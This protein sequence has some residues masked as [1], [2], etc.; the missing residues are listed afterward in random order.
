VYN[1]GLLSLVDGAERLG[2]T[3][4]AGLQELDAIGC[5]ATAESI[6]ALGFKENCTKLKKLDLSENKC[7]PSSADGAKQLGKTSCRAVGVVCI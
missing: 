6:K 2:K 7:L 3:L 5:G 1:K 4:P